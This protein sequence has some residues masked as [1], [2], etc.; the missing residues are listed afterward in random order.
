MNQSLSEIQLEKIT[1]HKTYTEPE[2]LENFIQTEF[3]LATPAKH[4][5]RQAVYALLELHPVQVMYTKRD[6]YICVGGIRSFSIA[7]NCLAPS[8]IIPVTLLPHMKESDAKK[9]CVTDILLTAACLSIQS[10]ESLYRYLQILPDHIK[11]EM[12]KQPQRPLQ[13]ARMLNISRETLRTWKNRTRT[14]P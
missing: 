9:R 3:M 10:K 11:H 4:L 13:L 12:L 14:Q 2:L 5:S 6:G 1:P 8:D 7:R